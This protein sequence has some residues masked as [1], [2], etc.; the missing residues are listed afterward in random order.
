MFNHPK[1]I[2]MLMLAALLGA[3]SLQAAPVAPNPNSLLKNKRVLIVEGQNK[4][5]H[6]QSSAN[7]DA[8]LALIKTEVGITTLTTLNSNSFTLAQ[9]NN[10]DIVVFNYFF[11]TQLMPAAS[12]TA[13]HTWLLSGGKGYVG[14]HTSGANEVNEWNWYRDSVTSMRYNLHTLPAQNGTIRV[15]TNAAILTQPI[16]QGLPA[17]FSGSDEWYD[18]DLPPRGPAAPTWVDCHVMYNLDE[19]TL[20][21]A[22]PRPMNPHP[23]AWYREDA[24]KTRYFYGI[25]VHSPT[26]A[27]SDF[28][29]SLILRAM[30]YVAGYAPTDLTSNGGSLRTLK[31]MSFIT[32]SHELRVELAGHYRLSVWS[33]QGKKLYAVQGEGQKTY[34]PEAFAKPGLYVVK[35]ESRAA[36]LI[37]RVMVY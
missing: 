9:L 22:L 29:H 34:S 28:F 12:Q 37:Q 18:F 5:G 2:H 27:S 24:N 33:P 11:E 23:A 1:T 17:T 30:E 25:I 3:L 31:G 7:A 10:Y 19:T 32:D 15:T 36:N 13:L 14:Y 16:M 8:I 35:L 20:A 4:T 26:G 6:E 21:T